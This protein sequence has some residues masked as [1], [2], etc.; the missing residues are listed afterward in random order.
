MKRAY[1][2]RGL[3]ATD[4]SIIDKKTPPERAGEAMKAK[5]VRE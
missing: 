3:K 2:G 4:E 5:P 1:R